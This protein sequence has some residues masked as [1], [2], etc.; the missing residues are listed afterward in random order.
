MKLVPARKAFSVKTI[1]H[2]Q[3]RRNSSRRAR[4]VAA[5]HGQAGH[6]SAQSRPMLT[7]AKVGY[8]VGANIE[9]T[10][11]G[12][13]GAVHRLAVKLGL[14]GEIDE[15]LQLL[16]VHLPYHESDHVLN[17]AYNVVCGL[18]GHAKSRQ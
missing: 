11:F 4:K 2:E 1:S 14:P 16:K 7:S 9:A 17:L 6:W 10:S 3:S 15:R 18:G 5:R 8:E 12:G 13:V